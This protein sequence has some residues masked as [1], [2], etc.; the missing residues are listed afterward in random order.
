[1]RL[2]LLLAEKEPGVCEA[3]LTRLLKLGPWSSEY[4]SYNE[5]KD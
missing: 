3:Q 2:C 4:N 1:M 5:G